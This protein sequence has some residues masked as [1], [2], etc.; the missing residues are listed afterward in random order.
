LVTNC[1]NRSGIGGRDNDL[2]PSGSITGNE[3]GTSGVQL[4]LKKEFSSNSINEEMGV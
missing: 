2:T 4:S 3:F 1:N